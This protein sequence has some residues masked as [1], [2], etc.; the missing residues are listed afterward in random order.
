MIGERAQQAWAESKPPQQ[1]ICEM[2]PPAPLSL[3]DSTNER[4]HMIENRIEGE[5]MQMFPG[6]RLKFEIADDGT[7]SYRLLPGSKQSF[8]EL[9]PGL[10]SAQAD[11]KILDD[12]NEVVRKH[13]PTARALGYERNGEYISM[14][15]G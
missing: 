14:A 10:S 7:W 15:K 2:L 6:L 9:Y 1:I 4:M 8:Y 3:S 11:A 12:I 5:L 13:L